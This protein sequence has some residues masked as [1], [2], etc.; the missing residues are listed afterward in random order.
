MRLKARLI[1]WARTE[2]LERH[3]QPLILTGEDDPL[4]VRHHKVV[5]LPCR[6]PLVTE[7]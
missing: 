2:I 1:G 6:E 5:S 4:R 3:M 7:R